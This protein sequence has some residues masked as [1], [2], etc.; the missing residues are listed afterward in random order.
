MADLDQYRVNPKKFSL[1]DFNARDKS[2]R[3]ITKEEDDIAFAMLV[4]EINRHQDI[5]HAEG[6][7]KVLLIF[8]GNTPQEQAGIDFVKMRIFTHIYLKNNLI[9][10][11]KNAVNQC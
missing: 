8:I 10:T 1:K 5:L 9:L 6:K 3:S 4:A 2:E 11:N 7:R